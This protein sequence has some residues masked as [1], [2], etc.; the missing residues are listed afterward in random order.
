MVV[1]AHCPDHVRGENDECQVD[2]DV[3][4]RYGDPEGQLAKDQMC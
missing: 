2:N 3:N 4:A 1:E